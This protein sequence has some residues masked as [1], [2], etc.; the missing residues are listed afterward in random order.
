MIDFRYHLV[1]I[2]AVFL[3]LAV[4]IVVGTAALNGPIV[5][6]LKA[7]ND[8]IIKDKRA[9]EGSVR[10]LRTQVSR[11]DD[12]ARAVAADVV[13]GEL[14]GERVLFVAGPGSSGDTIKQ[15]EELVTVAGGTPAGILRLRDD[16]LDPAKSQL[17]EDVVAEVRPAGLELPE[18][19]APVDRAAVELAAALVHKG[20][21]ASL[22]EEAAAKVLGGFTAA[23]L[24]QVDGPTGSKTP[25]D[26]TAPATMAVLVT[27]GSAGEA[28]DEAGE[29]RQRSLLTL[30]R[31]L[32]TRSKG[33]VV[34]GPET[35]ADTGG[36]LQA[37][38]GDGDLS[39]RVSSVDAADTPYGQVV[40]VLALDEQAA[41]RSGRYG[42]GAGAQAG[43]PSPAP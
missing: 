33:V 2:I 12:F 39:E 27:G 32:D 10:D 24:V 13:G 35:A 16:L 7:S 26:A 40:V 31:A 4:G 8:R 21:I 23:E 22:S 43:A 9:L 25:A 1:S 3:A 6:S 37:L 30:S 18:G 20:G 34:A 41:G 42:Q 11:R 15:L 29:Q 38:R 19:G 5:D 14:T 17:V 36:L 28:L